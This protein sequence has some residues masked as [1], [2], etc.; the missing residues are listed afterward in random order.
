MNTHAYKKGTVIFR[1]GDPS[2]CMYDIQWGSVGI[3][4]DYDGPNRKLIATLMPNQV[5]GEMGLLDDAPR[6]ATAVVLEN[7]TALETVSKDD[8]FAYY[9]KNPAKLLLIMQQMCYRL[10]A[11]TRDYVDAC[12]TVH[13]A[14]DAANEGKEKPRSLLQRIKKFCELYKDFTWYAHT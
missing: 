8:F 1:Q 3:Y 5:F 13:D 6:S 12:R 11:T 9:E 10:R 7:D 14:V 4:T 2:D